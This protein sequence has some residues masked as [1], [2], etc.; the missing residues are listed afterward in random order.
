MRL[1]YYQFPAEASEEVRLS[2]GCAVILKT[3][4][5]IWP[6]SIP[7]DKRHLVDHVG[8]TVGPTSITRIKQLI[9]QYGGCGYTEHYERDGGLFEVT[10]INLKGNNSRF[11]YNRHL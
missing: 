4:G 2:E 5:Q 3:G 1:S 10:P 9:K 11:K 7:D 6:E 8:D